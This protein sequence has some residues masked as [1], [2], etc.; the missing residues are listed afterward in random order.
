MF[1]LQFRDTTH[2]STDH[3]KLQKEFTSYL[4][5]ASNVPNAL[6]VILNVLYGRRFNLNLRYGS[7][8]IVLFSGRWRYGCSGLVKG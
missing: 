2:N 4:A 5:I 3:T 1:P 8:A 6:F 7:F